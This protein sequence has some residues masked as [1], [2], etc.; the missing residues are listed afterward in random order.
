MWRTVRD[1]WA[2]WCLD[3]LPP[4]DGRLRL[5]VYGALFVVALTHWKSPLRAAALHAGTD[6]LLYRAHGLI[7]ALGLPYLS[8]DALWAVTAATA[9]AWVFAAIG[10]F[11]RTSALVTAAGAFLIHGCTWGSIAFNHNWYLPV[12]VLGA[13]CFARPDPRWSADAWLRRRRGF[14]ERPVRPGLGGTGFARVLV[15]VL[16][17]GFYFCAGVTKLQTSGLAWADGHTI[18]WWCE[19]DASKRPLAAW[20]AGQPG[21]CSALAWLT[22]LFEVGAPLALWSRRL[23]PWFILGWIGMHVGIRL[24][25]GPRYYENIICFALLIDWGAVRVRGTAGLFGGARAPGPTPARNGLTPGEHAGLGLGFAAL[26]ATLLVAA[27]QINWWPLSHVYMYSAYYSREFGVRACEPE[28]AWS[29]A[30]GA[31][32]IARRLRDETVSFDAKEHLPRMAGL[33]LVRDGGPPL[34]LPAG[35]G[36]ATAKQWELVV[37]LPVLVEDLAGKPPGRIEDDPARPDAPA[38]RFL[39]A[40]VPVI[41]REVPSWRDYDR[42]ELAFETKDGFV[43]IGSVALRE[44]GLKALGTQTDND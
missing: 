43:P 30:A 34:R 23:R 25:M 44:D 19:E 5:F 32:R 36:V 3:E 29:D 39:R 18:A 28:A 6:P 26:A 41:R 2:R 1:R 37:E 40:L 7:G 13:L 9:L 14:P 10:L 33:R 4:L 31:Q 42:A 21:R 17:V 24:S 15:L 16:A 20:L 38:N 11:G 12:F 27:L 8:P 22:L 35:V